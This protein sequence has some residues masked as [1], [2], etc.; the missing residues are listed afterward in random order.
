MKLKFMLGLLPWLGLLGGC[1]ED[2]T[3]DDTR[4]FQYL[5]RGETAQS[6][7]KRIQVISSQSSYDEVFYQLLNRSGAPETIDFA[8]YQLL[9]VMPG[10]AQQMLKQDVLAFQGQNTQVEIRLSTH[11]A[12]ANCPAPAVVLQPWMLVL[13][14][15]VDKP[16]LV[17][18][19]VTVSAC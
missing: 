2:L 17:Q 14:P 18:E 1:V 6:G 12:G 15:R 19:Q 5:A 7:E 11:Y 3:A 9:L 4:A 10:S 8:Q 13:F 16:L